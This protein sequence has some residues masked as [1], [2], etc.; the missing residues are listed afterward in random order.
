MYRMKC[1]SSVCGSHLCEIFTTAKMYGNR[2]SCYQKKK[3]KLKVALQILGRQF[4]KNTKK[5]SLYFQTLL[6]FIHKNLVV[7]I[8]PTTRETRELLRP[9]S[10]PTGITFYFYMSISLIYILEIYRKKFQT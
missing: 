2:S 4:Y 7:E 5:T 1:K 6:I 9:R 8:R 10:T 3:K